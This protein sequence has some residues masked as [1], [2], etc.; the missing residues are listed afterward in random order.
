MDEELVIA[1]RLVS[2]AVSQYGSM[3]ERLIDCRA[4][5][6]VIFKNRLSVHGKLLL[7]VHKIDVLYEMLQPFF[8]DRT[9]SY[10]DV[11]VRLTGRS[12]PLPLRDHY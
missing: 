11:M 12:S 10:A 7:I 8:H 3:I 5:L 4:I 6:R 1:D 9:A 2:T